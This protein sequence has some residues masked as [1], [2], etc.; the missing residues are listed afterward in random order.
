MEEL[1]PEVN[2]FLTAVSTYIGGY[3]TFVAA[4]LQKGIFKKALP[5]IEKKFKDA[6]LKTEWYTPAMHKASM[7]LPRD[8]ESSLKKIDYGIELVM[9]LYNC[10]YETIQ[11]KKKLYQFAKELCQ[12]I[13]MKP[14]GEPLI[15]DFGFSLSKTAGPSLV[16]LIESSS[17]TAHY[18]PHWKL[19]CMN[20]FT[21]KSFDPEKTL[22]FVKSFFGATMAR[23]FLIKRGPRLFKDNLQIISVSSAYEI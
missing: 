1:F 20:V 10:D 21:C 18:S 19:V 13:E 6:K 7:I 12:V 15:P 2:V 5:G 17:I 23:A 9:D 8:L 22:K 4:S 11:S 3:F 16:Q 14:Y